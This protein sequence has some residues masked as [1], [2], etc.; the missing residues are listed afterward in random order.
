MRIVRRFSVPALV[1]GALLF[2]APAVRADPILVYEAFLSGAQEVPVHAVPGTGFGRVT[3]NAA[4]TEALV[5]LTWQDLTA[6]ASAGHIHGPAPIGTNAAVIFPFVGLAAATS[7]SFSTTWTLTATQLGWLQNGLLYMNIH[8]VN[9]PGGEIRGQLLATPEPASLLL[10][11]TGLL[12][13]VRYAR[14]RPS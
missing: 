1:V 6:P 9:F 4:M 7:G 11:A 8:N 5:E 12:G 10:L 14:R 3:L 2:V 13:V